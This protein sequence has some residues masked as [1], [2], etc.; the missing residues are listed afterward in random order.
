MIVLALIDVADEDDVLVAYGY[1][2][3]YRLYL[4]GAVEYVVHAY[5]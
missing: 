1:Q 4:C 5:G 3:E 2:S